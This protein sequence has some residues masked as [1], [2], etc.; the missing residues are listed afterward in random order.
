MGA[1]PL[2]GYAG[3]ASAVSQLGIGGLVT[4]MAGFFGSSA[5]GAAATAVVTSAVG[6]P[7][8]MAIILAGGIAVVNIGKHQAANFAFDK[9]RRI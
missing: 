9:L 7:I 4:S 3:M 5:T 6:G 1:G 8:V 2:A